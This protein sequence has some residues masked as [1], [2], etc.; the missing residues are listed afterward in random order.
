[1]LVE[2]LY[3]ENQR[4]FC[5]QKKVPLFASRSCDHSYGWNRERDN[6]GVLQTLG[7]ILLERYGSEDEASRISSS[8]H[9]TGCPGCGRSWCD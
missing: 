8:T 4:I 2:D 7:E 1:M 5:E 6:H 3:Y 9:I